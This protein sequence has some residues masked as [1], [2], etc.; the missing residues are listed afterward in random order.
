MQYNQKTYSSIAFSLV[1]KWSSWQIISRSD[2]V[3][4]NDVHQIGLSLMS[5]MPKG[6]L[7]I[8][9]VSKARGSFINYVNRILWIFD[10]SF[11]LRRQCS[12]WFKFCVCCQYIIRTDFFRFSLRKKSTFPKTRVKKYHSIIEIGLFK[13]M[14]RLFLLASLVKKPLNMTLKTNSRYKK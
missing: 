7:P 10:P 14:L 5:S 8:D 13:V 3:L 1:E 11:P 6:G 2:D 12:F 9:I 4:R